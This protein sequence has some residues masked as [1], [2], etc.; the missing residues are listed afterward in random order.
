MDATTTPEAPAQTVNGLEWTPQLHT[1]DGR[2]DDTHEEFVEMLNRLVSEAAPG[3]LS[4][5]RFSHS[6]CV[7][8]CALFHA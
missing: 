4:A 1:G 2:M 5:W 8:S 6:S 7:R 3:I